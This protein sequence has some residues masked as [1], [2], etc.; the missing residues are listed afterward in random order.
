[1][2]PGPQRTWWNPQQRAWQLENRATLG[3]PYH[4]SLVMLVLLCLWEFPES[5]IHLLLYSF[6]PYGFR[7][8]L[9]YRRM[10][11]MKASTLAQAVELFG[12]R[13]W[14][15]K[16]QPWDIS[17]DAEKPN[18]LSISN[19][20]KKKKILMRVEVTC[21]LSIQPNHLGPLYNLHNHKLF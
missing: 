8:C 2:W 6:F 14:S 15:T 20:K 7:M 1:M 10:D 11:D 4:Y 5:L 3:W 17:K 16:P 21:L 19:T 13:R 18:T 9:F 12:G